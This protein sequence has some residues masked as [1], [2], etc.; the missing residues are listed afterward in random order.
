[1]GTGMT[2]GRATPPPDDNSPTPWSDYVRER[3]YDPSPVAEASYPSA[4]RVRVA[5]AA[6]F[7]DP[8]LCV[9]P[10]PE[11][12][13]WLLQGRVVAT[14]VEGADHTSFVLA[15]LDAGP[16]GIFTVDTTGRLRLFALHPDAR[17]GLGAMWEGMRG[18]V[19]RLVEGGE[20]GLVT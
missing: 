18:V 17:V 10:F 9:R 4:E 1:M 11:G 12:A 15:S 7:G 2:K 13:S 16:M 3:G 19:E 8:R 5:L 20:D 14:L 6:C